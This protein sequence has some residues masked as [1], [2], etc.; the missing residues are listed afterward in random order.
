MMRMDVGKFKYFD[1]RIKLIFEDSVLRK[2]W[3]NALFPSFLF[4]A[5]LIWF[6]SY[7]GVFDYIHVRP[8]SIHS[9]A[10]CQRAS[11]ALNY[12]EN[13]MNFFKPRIQKYSEMGGVTGVEF[14]ILYYLDAVVYKLF[15][16]NEAG[17]RWVSLAIVSLGFYLFFL[18]ANNVLKS[19]FLSIAVVGSAAFSPVLLFYT[20]NFMP[21]APS[22]ALVLMAWYYFFRYTKT[23]RV[24]HLNLFFVLATLA[25]LIKVVALIALVIIFCLIVL[26]KLKFFKKSQQ[27]P[28]FDKPIQ[29]LIKIGVSFLVVLA[30]YY[31]AG[32]LAVAYKNETFS[33]SPVMGD[34]GTL[35]AVIKNIKE[36]WLFHYY[37]KESYILLGGAIVFTV[38][39]A[40]YTNR[41]LAS[42]TG[43][44]F[45]G[46]LMFVY[47]FLN[48]FIN[49]DYYIISILP[50]A[51]FILLTFV[52]CLVKV[53]NA[54]FFSLKIIFLV[55]VFFNMK[56]SLINCQRN[57]NMRY[58]SEIYYWTGD[59]R[60]YYDLEQELRRVGIKRTDLTI[61]GF[62]D[63]F[64]SSLYLMN[65]IGLTIGSWEGKEKIDEMIKYKDSKYLILNDTTT[66]NKKYPNNL[67]N[68][69]ILNHR[70]LIVYKLK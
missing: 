61:S 12:Y 28:L 24:V 18:L 52:D 62:D 63:T 65:Q 16:F 19:S 10:Q 4:V 22:V 60:P 49:H 34:A 48:Q 56:E 3:A 50:L 30:W 44:Y 38:I 41:I 39:F 47:F 5:C 31:Y 42:I 40:K 54:H 66:F 8:T 45:L 33:L 6:Y 68:K 14:P 11:I 9:S 29:V 1:S 55:I 35:Q 59:F 20:P 69:I 64:C 23:R 58:S 67:A 70:G 17:A 53:S 46:N 36:L 32:W 27:V 2:T 21:D 51:F 7:V 15:G 43:L 57:Y 25:S 13:D 37:A 26:D